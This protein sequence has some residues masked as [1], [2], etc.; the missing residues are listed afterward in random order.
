MTF[1]R[2]AWPFVLPVWL[3]ALLLAFPFGHYGWAAAVATIGLAVLLFFRVPSVAFAGGPA[4]LAAP[5]HGL[6]TRVDEIEAPEV[7]PGRWRRVVT[8]LSVFDVHV[9]RV[10]AD[11]RVVRSTSRPGRKVA[12]FRHDADEL[13][14]GHLSVLELAGGERIAVRQVAGLLARRVVCDLAL[15]ESRRRGERL[16]II[17]FGSRVDLLLPLTYRVLVAK[18]DRVRGGETPI[19]EPLAK[20]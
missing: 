15:G 14:A 19:A 3:A 4:S 16:G 20:P 12:A 5:A 10:P 18:G 8:F 17:K 7:G 6:V 9:Q 1:A 13:N 11:S 2:E